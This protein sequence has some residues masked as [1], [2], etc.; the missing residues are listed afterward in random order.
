VAIVSK[1]RNLLIEV[2]ELHTSERMFQ[3]EMHNP[4]GLNI[5]RGHEFKRSYEHADFIIEMWTVKLVSV[6]FEFLTAVV[7][8]YNAL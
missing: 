5:D 6:E 1:F 4:C 8:R 2:I 7:M 3:D